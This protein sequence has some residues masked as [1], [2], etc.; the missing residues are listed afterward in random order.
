MTDA[1]TTTLQKLRFKN[2]DTVTREMRFEYHNRPCFYTEDIDSWSTQWDKGRYS[3]L[4]Q[5]TDQGKQAPPSGMR[6]AVPLGGLGAGTVELRADGS[7]R[8]WNIF[9][10]S[11]GGGGPKVHLDDAFFALR[12]DDGGGEVTTRVLRT[13]PPRFLPGVEQIVYSGAYPVS[14]LVFSDS[15]QPVS[16]TLYA[17]SELNLRSPERSATPGVMF[18]FVMENESAKAVDASVMFTL[19]NHIGGEYTGGG[20]LVLTREGREPTSGTMALQVSGERLS[21]SALAADTVFRIWEQFSAGGDLSLGQAN[22]KEHPLEK[23]KLG[24]ADARMM[25]GALAAETRLGPGECKTVTF[26]LGWHFPFR[27]HANETPGNYYA[28]LYRDAQEV[29]EIVAGRAEQTWES[30]LEWQRL[31]FDNTLPEWLQDAMVNS[32]GTMAKTGIWVRDGR[33]RQWESFSC[34]TIDPVH[35]HFYRVLP[36]AWFFPSLRRS[37]IRCFA[38]AQTED[39]YIQEKMGYKDT[40]LDQPYGRNMGDGCTAFI[41]VVYQDYLWMGDREFT[42][43]VWPMVKKAAEWQ[44]NRAAEFGLPDRLDNSYDWFA[45]AD[46]DLVSYNAFLHLAALKAAERLAVVFDG[47]EFAES[48]RNAFVA[49]QESVKEHF[50]TGEYYRSWWLKEG[51]YPDA[52][53]ADTLY[54]QLWAEILDLERLVEPEDLRS[55]LL[56]EQR[57]NASPFG[58]KVMQ[59]TDRDDD[60]HPEIARGTSLYDDGPVN[61]LVWEAGA[62]D[63]CSLNIYLGGD[64]D[65]SLDEAQKIYVKWRDLLKDQW[66]IRDLSTGW[67]GHPWCN[68]HYARQLMLWAIPLAL[69]GQRYSAPERSLTFEPKVAAPAVLPFMTPACHGVLELPEGQE[70]KVKIHSGELDVASP[71]LIRSTGAELTVM[72]N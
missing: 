53:H 23:V 26:V 69:S 7:L 6:S 20:G 38:T 40:P 68:S 60:R 63:W 42:A 19:P 48:C 52:L 25:C 18:A 31:C 4:Y 46:K 44:I 11:P 71:V 61:S 24:G 32:L 41:L 29:V 64:V 15:T 5:M 72:R 1:P 21:I 62:L 59:G 13:H 34:P 57:K 45:F 37:Q 49:A 55:H 8:D 3:Y 43:E 10:N 2:S 36:Y 16:L 51:A 67:D 35:I 33:W 66:D 28:N 9:N 54:G 50:W 70:A 27:P 47:G 14:R 56:C 30:I 22:D 65:E 39:G 58:L 12:V 17:C